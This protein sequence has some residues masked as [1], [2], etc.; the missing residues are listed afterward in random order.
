MKTGNAQ[1]MV[2]IYVYKVA[3]RFADDNRAVMVREK[4][5]KVKE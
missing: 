3:T 4:R 5:P 1:G 2:S